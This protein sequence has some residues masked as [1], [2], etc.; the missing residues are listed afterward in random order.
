MTIHETFITDTTMWKSPCGG[1]R[2]TRRT[3]A[4][5]GGSFCL[6][7]K[8]GDDS[9]ARDRSWFEYELELSH[10]LFDTMLGWQAFASTGTADL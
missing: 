10:R 2:S 3:G 7:W 9:G 4:L 1:S 5:A 8:F 6:T